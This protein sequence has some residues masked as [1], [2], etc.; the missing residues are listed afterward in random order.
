MDLLLSIA[1]GIAM[2][3]H[4]W[5]VHLKTASLDAVSG[6]GGNPQ[7]VVSSSPVAGP[8]VALSGVNGAGN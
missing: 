8:P 4:C 6:S 2:L 1:L 3:G 5:Y 7:V